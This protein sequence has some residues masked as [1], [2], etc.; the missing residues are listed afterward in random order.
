VFDSYWEL[1][2][3]I[4]MEDMMKLADISCEE[5]F[6]NPI[7]RAEYEAYLD[8]QAEIQLEADK[9]RDYNN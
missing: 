7:Y 2:Y 9:E 4:G 8:E 6:E 1:A 3:N 5:V